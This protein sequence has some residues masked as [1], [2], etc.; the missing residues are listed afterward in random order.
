MRVKIFDIDHNG[1]ETFR[2]LGHLD[3]CFPERDAE[4]YR[5]M[6]QLRMVGRY[7]GGGGASP[8]FL[9]LRDGEA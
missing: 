2:D 7:W 6:V 8:M 4:Y 1:N 9:L 5:A 3:E